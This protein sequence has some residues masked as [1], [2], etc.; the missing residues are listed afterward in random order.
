MTTTIKN[1]KLKILYFM[2]STFFRGGAA[3]S[4]FEVIKRIKEDD[5]YEITVLLF[6]VAN[7]EIKA[8]LI[9]LDV[10]ILLIN[11]NTFTI[12]GKY[13]IGW[14]KGFNFLKTFLLILKDLFLSILALGRIKKLIIRLNPDIIHF[15]SS[16]LIP[17]AFLLPNNYKKIIHI[18]ESLIKMTLLR[19]KLLIFF[20]KKPI[21]LICISENEYLDYRN[22]TN[23]KIEIIGNP[24]SPKSL[25]SS[26]NNDVKVIGCL[27]GHDEKKGG[28]IFIKSLNRINFPLKIKFAGPESNKSKYS[29]DILKEI[30]SLEKNNFI[31]LENMGLI[32]DIEKF[33][34]SCDL[35]VVPHV[36]PHFS[37]VI[38]EAWAYSKPVITFLDPW[39]ESLNK[40]SNESLILV[41]KIDEVALNIKIKE[42]F[43]NKID[44]NEKSKKGHDY[45]KKN[46]HPE[47]VASQVKKFYEKSLM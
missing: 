17:V 4:I 47:L 41:K 33:M 15:N 14:L 6:D 34:K 22:L 8:K 25:E 21:N 42:V 36:R 38:I 10:K 44:L 16:V 40:Y 7:D 2:H 18:R 43:H 3:K 1:K 31:T 29:K 32:E 12:F 37:R 5:T 28:L 9:E 35:L 20:L 13:L 46:H 23:S 39:T 45:W 27:A 26:S 24:I 11:K 30:E 19:S